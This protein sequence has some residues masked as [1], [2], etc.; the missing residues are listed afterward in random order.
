[1]K[2]VRLFG[3]S[4]LLVLL[5]VGV[6]AAKERFATGI[7]AYTG[8]GTVYELSS[9][10]TTANLTTT[11]P[12]VGAKQ[13]LVNDYQGNTYGAYANSN[14]TSPLYSTIAW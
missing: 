6:F 11:A 10:Y 7:Y 14:G 12:V 13:V 4:A 1:M 8:S 3:F 9:T 2:K 5:T